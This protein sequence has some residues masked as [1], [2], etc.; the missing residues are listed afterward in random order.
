LVATV[1]FEDDRR[2]N[3]ECF[4]HE[5]VRA[6]GER[7]AR[8]PDLIISLR[9]CSFKYH[10]VPPKHNYYISSNNVCL[11]TWS[12]AMLAYMEMMELMNEFLG[13]LQGKY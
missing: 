5:R 8:S 1:H 9:I 4:Q 11:I 12:G 7:R 2:E 13:I 3:F 6:C 10:A